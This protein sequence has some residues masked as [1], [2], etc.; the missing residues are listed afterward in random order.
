MHSTLTHCL[1][2]NIF[3]DQTHLESKPICRRQHLSL[4][5][6]LHFF[7]QNLR[8]N[9]SRCHYISTPR[10]SLT[11]VH[12]PLVYSSRMQGSSQL[13]RR[14]LLL[15]SSFLETMIWTCYPLQLSH[16][17]HL[18]EH[19]HPCHEPLLY[20]TLISPLVKPH[21]LQTLLSLLITKIQ[22]LTRSLDINGKCLLHLQIRYNSLMLNLTFLTSQF[23]K[24]YTRRIPS[25]PRMKNPVRRLTLE[26]NFILS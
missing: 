12:Q 16:N 4:S 25:V 9:L 23:F 17:H 15:K 6:C 19:L 3:S 11:Q 24:R 20:Q 22:V 8:S 18:L 10:A 7:P 21:L 1:K 5:N 26:G 13:T 14:I 2:L